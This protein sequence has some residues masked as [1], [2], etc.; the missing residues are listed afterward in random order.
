[1]F[2]KIDQFSPVL[3]FATKVLPNFCIVVKLCEKGS[4]SEALL[5]RKR[6]RSLYF[7]VDNDAR[8]NIMVADSLSGATVWLPFGWM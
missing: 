4:K 7:C 5:L 3:R 2:R 8:R 1:M 6:K